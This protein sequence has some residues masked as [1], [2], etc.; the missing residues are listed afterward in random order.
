MTNV[1]RAMTALRQMIFSGEL[2][3]GSDHMETERAD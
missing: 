2:P 1:E 3:P